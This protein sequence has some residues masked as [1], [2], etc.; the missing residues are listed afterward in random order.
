MKII[1]IELIKLNINLILTL[2]ATLR[3]AFFSRSRSLFSIIHSRSLFAL[4]FCSSL[5]FRR[6]VSQMGY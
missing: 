3:N 6:R 4:S 5:L 2:N 1:P